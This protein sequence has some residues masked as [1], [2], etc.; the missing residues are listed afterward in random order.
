MF[1]VIYECMQPEIRLLQLLTKFLH[2]YLKSSIEVVPT[3]KISLFISEMFKSFLLKSAQ[4]EWTGMGVE[5]FYIRIMTLLSHHRRPSLS[6]LSL[7]RGWRALHLTFQ[8]CIVSST[9]SYV[10]YLSW[11]DHSDI[12]PNTAHMKILTYLAYSISRSTKRT[13]T[14]KYQRT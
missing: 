4:N 5:Q 14:W 11:L 1:A 2:S 10:Q 9:H 7:N 8:A 3:A 12:L 13:G 6:R